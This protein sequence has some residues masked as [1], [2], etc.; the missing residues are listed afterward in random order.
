MSDAMRDGIVKQFPD[1]F[2]ENS[3]GND[4]LRG[5]GTRGE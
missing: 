2:V 1:K 3:A 4:Q 5:S